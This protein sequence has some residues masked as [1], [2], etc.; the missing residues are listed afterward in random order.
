MLR[1]PMR[2]HK[3]VNPP[4]PAC[5]GNKQNKPESS[6]ALVQ[7]R[8]IQPQT[9]H[10]ASVFNYESGP[11]LCMGKKNDGK[12]DGKNVQ[13]DIPMAAVPRLP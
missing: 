9:T 8:I 6:P 10:K 12:S 7:K 13:G 11:S 2:R 1:L 4:S 5:E 3:I